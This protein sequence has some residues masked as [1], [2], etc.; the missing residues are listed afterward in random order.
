MVKI[1]KENLVITQLDNGC[2]KDFFKYG[3]VTFSNLSDTN[4]FLIELIYLLLKKEG[5]YGYS[6]YNNF[7]LWVDNT[8]QNS[9]FLT[10]KGV[11]ILRKENNEGRKFYRID[12]NPQTLID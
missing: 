2:Q 10:K 3:L 7:I 5:C 6:Y 11:F 1:S 12:F 4:H 8:H 9:L